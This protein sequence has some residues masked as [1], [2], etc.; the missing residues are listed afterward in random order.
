MNQAHELI[1]ID[2]R[3]GS[4]C[5]LPAAKDIRRKKVRRHVIQEGEV[6]KVSPDVKHW[7]DAAPDTALRI[8][9]TPK[10]KRVMLNGWNP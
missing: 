7:H 9:I 5:L 10:P 4:F 2:I 6:E 1:G 8:S 3:V